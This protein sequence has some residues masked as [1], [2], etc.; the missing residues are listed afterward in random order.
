MK[1]VKERWDIE[2]PEQASMYDLRNNAPRFQKESEIR[3]S[4][5]VRNRNEID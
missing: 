3:K 2:F 1:R 5:L 4:T